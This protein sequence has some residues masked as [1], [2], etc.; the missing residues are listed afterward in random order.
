[1]PTDLACQHLF[2]QFLGMGYKGTMT[3]T[4]ILKKFG[5]PTAARKALGVS[6]QTLRNWKTGGIPLRTQQW[7][8]LQTGGALKADK[9]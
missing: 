7:I 2:A 4:Q 8:Q 6:L 3:H 1:M 5:T 9:A